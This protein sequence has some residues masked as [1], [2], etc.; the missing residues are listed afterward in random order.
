MNEHEAEHWKEAGAAAIPDSAGRPLRCVWWDQDPSQAPQ[1]PR[2]EQQQS[3]EHSPPLLHVPWVRA[4][5]STTS[6]LPDMRRGVSAEADT[7]ERVVRE[8]EVSERD[9]TQVGRIAPRSP[10]AT[11]RLVALGNGQ[12]PQAAALAWRIL[13]EQI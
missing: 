9:G 4:Q 10:A 2:P 11:D 12:V 8:T 3:G 13:S 6:Q 1:R 5:E 7:S